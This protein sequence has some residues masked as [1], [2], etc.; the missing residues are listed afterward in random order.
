MAKYQS[1]DGTVEESSI[2]HFQSESSDIIVE[3][4]DLF[5]DVLHT[6]RLLK[7]KRINQ[8]TTKQ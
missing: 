3:V 2:G 1:D 7:K 8:S 6:G 5:I 4:L